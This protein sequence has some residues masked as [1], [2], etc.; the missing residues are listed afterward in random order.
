MDPSAHHNRE[1]APGSDGGGPRPIEP[2]HPEESERARETEA[3]VERP[4]AGNSQP[5]RV[6][7]VA[8]AAMQRVIGGGQRAISAVNIKALTA[9]L[10]QMPGSIK[11]A[12][13]PQAKSVASHPA[14]TL[15]DITKRVKELSKEIK[16]Y[17]P[18]VANFATSV[19][20]VAT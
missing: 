5:A 18:V 19:E 10:M 17:A 1:P 20:A 9:R 8:T 3:F 2:A 7:R 14:P 13:A 6:Q 15:L 4:R 11:N 16:L 12:F